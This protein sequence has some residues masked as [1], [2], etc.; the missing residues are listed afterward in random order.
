MTGICGQHIC[1][2]SEEEKTSKE[3]NKYLNFTM[4]Y[5][6]SGICFS[7]AKV[8]ENDENLLKTSRHTSVPP[9][10]ILPPYHL[11]KVNAL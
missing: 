4:G 8:F 7:D 9:C 5:S 3:F 10:N 6:R 1:I 11:Q 2:C